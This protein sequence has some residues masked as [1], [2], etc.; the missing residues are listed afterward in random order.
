MN[1]RSLG[2]FLITLP[3]RPGKKYEQWSDWFPDP[4]PGRPQ[5]PDTEPSC[6]Y[7]VQ[8]IIP[9]PPPPDPAVVDAQKLAALKPDAPLAEYLS[10]LKRDAPAE[11]YQAVDKVIEQRPAELAQLIRSDD[12]NLRE[13]ALAVV[14][15]LSR[16]TPEIS[17]A[18][19]AEQRRLVDELKQF[20][21]M[22]PDDPKFTDVQ[23]QL[24][25]R[26]NYWHQAWWTV[27][28]LTGV[29]GRPPVQ[30]LLDL[31]NVRAK[32]TTLDEIVANAQA[33]LDGIKQVPAK[34]P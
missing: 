14:T 20:N 5:W 30:E 15:R 4:P 16:I 3:A 2:G 33:H 9:P 1:G 17:D 21:E 29:D 31:A 23:I 19:L 18:V 25:T 32:D 24:R 34:T 27:H 26:F 11:R 28:Q 12:S 10:F 7:R 6:R 22:K 8:Q 13:P